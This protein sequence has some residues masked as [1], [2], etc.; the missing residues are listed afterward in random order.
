MDSS[1]YLLWNLKD[2]KLLDLSHD[3]D[4][5]QSMYL[6]MENDY[7]IYLIRSKRRFSSDYKYLCKLIFI[8][9]PMNQTILELRLSEMNIFNMIDCIT[10]YSEDNINDISISIPNSPDSSYYIHL[11]HNPNVYNNTYFEI[12]NFINRQIKLKFELD[13]ESLSRFI[14]LLYFTFLFDID[15][16]NYYMNY[17]IF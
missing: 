1:D 13:E 11:Y 14:D 6:T 8:S 16:N 2:M 17:D 15:T 12:V 7:K 5:S 9:N 3:I 4:D 10:F